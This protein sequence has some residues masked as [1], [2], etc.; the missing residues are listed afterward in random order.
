MREAVDAADLEVR[1]RWLTLT[2][3]V[4]FGVALLAGMVL[5]LASP[6]SALSV[7]FLQAGLV[8]LMAAPGV[9]ILIAVAERI[10]RQDWPFVLMTLVVIL[11]LAIVLWRAAAAS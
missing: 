5:H 8:L 4:S 6:G 2:V 7:R 11:E 3:V 10:R 9:R 1:L